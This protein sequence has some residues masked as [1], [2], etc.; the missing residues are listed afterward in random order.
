MYDTAA[1]HVAGMHNLSWE[2]SNIAAGGSAQWPFS[3]I[4]YA[5]GD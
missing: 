5:F 3:A 2:F 1:L 4:Y